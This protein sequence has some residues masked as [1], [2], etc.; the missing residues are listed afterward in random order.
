MCNN[1]LAGKKPNGFIVIRLDCTSYQLRRTRILLWPKRLDYE[2]IYYATEGRKTQ[3]GI[4]V[5]TENQFLCV[6]SAGMKRLVTAWSKKLAFE[7]KNWSSLASFA[8]NI[9][10]NFSQLLLYSSSA[11][12][13]FPQKCNKLRKML[14]HFIEVQF[15]SFLWQTSQ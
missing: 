14:K 10:E 1:G 11:T 9:F 8:C 13:F 15:S 6:F 5:S 7:M 3:K 4:F 12:D 2:N